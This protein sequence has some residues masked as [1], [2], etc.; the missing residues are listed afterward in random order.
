[1]VGVFSAGMEQE[2]YDGRSGS[3]PVLCHNYIRCFRLMGLWGI[4]IHRGVVQLEWP[5]SWRKV[6]I[7]VKELLPVVLG[8][9]LCS[10]QWLGRNIRCRCCNTAMVAILNFGSSKDLAHASNEE[11][12]FLP[13]QF[14]CFL[15][16]GTHP[17]GRK[18]ASR[19]I[20]KR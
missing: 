5:E 13:S 18:W 20:I 3:V 12:I 15:I 4:L 2:R 8:V 17:R 19:Y 10:S 9:A 6:R 11:P 7:A 16:W 14:Q 1:M